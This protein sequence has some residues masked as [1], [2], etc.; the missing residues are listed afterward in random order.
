M[1]KQQRGVSEKAQG[2]SKAHASRKG[3]PLCFVKAPLV[4]VFYVPKAFRRG[5]I[6]V[7]KAASP[8]KGS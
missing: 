3:N 5:S 8:Q 2:R 4:Y 7:D 1:L 6:D